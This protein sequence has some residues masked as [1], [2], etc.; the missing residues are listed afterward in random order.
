MAGTWI[1]KQPGTMETSSKLKA[2]WLKSF[3]GYEELE[4]KLRPRKRLFGRISY[5]RVWLLKIN[6]E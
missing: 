5:E 6:E 4:Q 2:W 3:H 1:R